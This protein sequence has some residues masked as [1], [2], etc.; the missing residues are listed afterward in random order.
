MFNI[1]P[2]TAILRALQE[3]A[4]LYR[5]S[6]VYRQA[7]RYELEDSGFVLLPCCRESGACFDPKVPVRGLEHFHNSRAP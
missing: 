7:F 6:A 1:N 3:G 5:A 2:T 4:V